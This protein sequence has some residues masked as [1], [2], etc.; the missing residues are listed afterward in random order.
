M[1]VDEKKEKKKEKML[2]FTNFGKSPPIHL[3][4]N[5]IYIHTIHNTRN[6]YFKIIVL[7][8]NTPTSCRKFHIQYKQV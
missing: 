3:I 2:N 8:K 6:S 1:G 5:T 7:H 4:I